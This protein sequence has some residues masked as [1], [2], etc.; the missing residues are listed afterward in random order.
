MKI[1]K[2]EW[3]QILILTVPF[4][5]AALFWNKLP[6]RMPIRWDGNSHPVAYGSKTIG[7][8]LLPCVNVLVAVL[9]MVL[10]RMDPKFVGYDAETKASLWHTF[11]IMRC[12]ITTLLSAVAL[13]GF[14]ATLHP[15]FPISPIVIAGIAALFATFGNQLT[16][17]RPNWFFGIRTPWTLESR[18]AWVKTHRLGGK[19]MMGGGVSLLVLLVP[20]VRPFFVWIVL[21]VVALIAIVPIVYSYVV[22]TRSRPAK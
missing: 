12:A 21:S 8:L 22:C 2:R 9:M 20:A 5:V 1:P 19:L 3:L 10:P 18:E 7:A 13:A 16:K 15:G 17:L 4:L 14:A 11:A 6:D